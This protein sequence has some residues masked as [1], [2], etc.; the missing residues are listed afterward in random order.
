MSNVLSP[1]EL[2]KEVINRVCNALGINE[3]VNVVH[4]HISGISYFNIGDYGLKL[5]KDLYLGGGKFK[6][7][8]TANPYAVV[9]TDFRGLRLDESI[10]NKQY[11][12]VKYLTLLGAKGFT[13]APYFIR[14][15]KPN[16]HLAWAESNAVLLANSY[17]G[18]KTNRE[19][20]PSALMSALVG[21]TC[22]SEIHKGNLSPTVEIKAIN[23]RNE[24]EA[25]ALGYLI[26]KLYPHEVPYVLGIKV[27]DLELIRSLL[28]A[29]GASA[30]SPILIL[31]SV[32]PKYTYGEVSS[33]LL[34]KNILTTNDLRR[35][36][37]DVAH[38]DRELR[39]DT[40]FIVGCP[41]LKSDDVIKLYEVLKELSPAKYS[42]ELWVLV[43]D[44][45][46][47]SNYEV[48]LLAS[49]G[50]KILEHV[51]PVVT[52]LSDFGVEEVITNSF[53]ALHYIPKI[54]KIPTYVMSFKEIIKLLRGK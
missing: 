44:S 36:I 1:Y 22:N 19:G 49:K 6:V 33:D 7:Y 25:S 9:N 47:L 41:H 26:G 34:D 31:D 12:I 37:K 3:V 35:F 21:Y 24:L 40:L 48:K 54:S 45:V 42:S 29:F 11:E 39:K 52:R 16:E 8:T 23:P 32:T 51:C 20:G 14:E 4:A 38:H 30:S 10:I 15:P 17:Y 2:A 46:P 53:K 5:I 28:A 27:K 13:C 50:V 43:H 18:A